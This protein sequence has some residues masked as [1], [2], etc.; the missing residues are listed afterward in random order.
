MGEKREENYKRR[1]SSNKQSPPTPPLSLL[2]DRLPPERPDPGRV[3]RLEPRLGQRRPPE[4]GRLCG[5]RPGRLDP[6]AGVV[7]LPG[8]GRPP[9]VSVLGGLHVAFDERLFW[10]YWGGFEGGAE[11]ERARKECR[12]S[13]KW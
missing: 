3:R 4:A 13:G 5:Q 11:R 12:K 8:V 10:N 2:V 9:P 7:D 1:A 6:L